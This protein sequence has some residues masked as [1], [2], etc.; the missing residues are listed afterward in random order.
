LIQRAVS[1]NPTL[2]ADSLRIEQAKL[3]AS[4][5]V[6]PSK[7]GVNAMVGQYNSNFKRDNNFTIQQQIPFPTAFFR[8]KS[9]GESLSKERKLVYDLEQL[10]LKEKVE[11]AIEQW[12]YLI[13]KKN[14]LTQ[15]DSVLREISKGLK[16]KMS[17]GDNNPLE[18]WLFSS[19]H[20][21]VQQNLLENERL[22]QE[23][24][25]ELCKLVYLSQGE[26]NSINFPYEILPIASDNGQND[27]QNLKTW[28]VMNQSLNT[29]NDEQKTQRALALPDIQIGYFNQTLVG[30][31]P[32]NGGVPFT[33]ADRFQGGNIGF[34]I[35]LM[36]RS[37]AQ[38]NKW[39]TI[40]QRRVQFEI[41]SWSQDVILE[42]NAYRFEYQ[43]YLSE[44]D[45]LKTQMKQILT[46]IEQVSMVQ[47]TQGEM[48][49]LTWL[50]LKRNAFKMSLSEL[51]MM[52]QLNLLSLKIRYLGTN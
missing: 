14:L 51:D 16:L 41:K 18:V 34:S 33:A 27:V 22:L 50:T 46:G 38:R 25:N 12:Q 39:L 9:Y 35:P 37:Y 52:H 30:N 1:M 31:V 28:M 43:R 6:Q 11:F 29:L 36:T 17:S 10:K 8:A 3:E 24:T 21:L 44:Y 23:S 32:L 42:G 2:K 45:I 15:E 47:L 7:L 40:E 5:L 49:H 19:E 4:M 20:V 13:S 48:D 26:L